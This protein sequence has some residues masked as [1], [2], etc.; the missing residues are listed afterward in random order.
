MTLV[1]TKSYAG[2]IR[3]RLGFL[4]SQLS[5]KDKAVKAN[6]AFEVTFVRYS[7]DI[8]DELW[9]AG[10]PS[11][12]EGRWLYEALEQSG[13]DAQFTFLYARVARNGAAAGFAPVFVMD[14]PIEE[15]TPEPLRKPLHA[16]ARLFPSVLY[17]RTLFVGAPCSAEGA[18][19]VLPGE[20]RHE[21]LLALQDALEKKSKELG[22]E[23]IVW[24]DMPSGISADLDR[25]TMRRRLFRVVSLPATL[26]NFSSQKKS[27]YFGQLKGS[28]RSALKKKLKLSTQ[29]ADVSV[30]VL[31]QPAPEVLDEIFGLFRQTY[32][33]SKTKFE[34]LN[35]TWFDRIGRDSGDLLCRSEGEANERHARL[36]GLF[37]LRLPPSQQT[38]RF[39][40]FQARVLDALFPSVGRRCR[41]GLSEGLYVHS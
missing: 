27:D 1:N 37:R 17:Q 18:I 6:A 21:V 5:F 38:C 35:R 26:V 39:R 22:A 40:L 34:E 33:K 28:R 20:N 8:P 16:V 36:H 10:L 31:Q 30:E 7:A 41:L 19:A 13:L 3:P 25:L 23:M 11:P 12:L 2:N 15:V 24:K 14:V 9:A 32:L 29:E 4:A